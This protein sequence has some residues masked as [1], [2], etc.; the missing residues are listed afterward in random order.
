MDS[1]AQLIVDIITKV[2]E[3]KITIANAVRWRAREQHLIDY[4]NKSDTAFFKID[5][6]LI[7]L[8]LSWTWVLSIFL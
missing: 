8:T 6:N 5:E 4:V 1:K 3:R 7:C 2:S